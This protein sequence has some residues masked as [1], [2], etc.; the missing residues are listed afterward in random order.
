M[1]GYKG[2]FYVLIFYDENKIRIQKIAHD[3]NNGH[4]FWMKRYAACLVQKTPRGWVMPFSV[5][6]AETDGP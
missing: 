3:V 4:R 5:C 1:G 2:E 6:F